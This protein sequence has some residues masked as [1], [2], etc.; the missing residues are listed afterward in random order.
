MNRHQTMPGLRR[1][2]A[3]LLLILSF[4]ALGA[5]AEILVAVEKIGDAFLVDAT[6]A[7]QVIS[8]YTTLAPRCNLSN[9]REKTTWL[10]GLKR[11]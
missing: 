1:V 10:A 6:V 9:F 8:L 11:S 2:A 7:I 3:I 5:E 4:A